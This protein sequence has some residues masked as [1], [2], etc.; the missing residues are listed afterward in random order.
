MRPLYSFMNLIQHRFASH[1]CETL[2]MRS[3]PVVTQ[4]MLEPVDLEA[5]IPES[6]ELIVS[7]ENLFLFAINELEGNLG[8][9]MTDRFAS[10]ALRV[11]LIVLSGQPFE[12][13]SPRSVLKSKRKEH[14]EVPRNEGAKDKSTEKRATPEAFM[15]ALEKMIKNSLLGLDTGYLRSLATHQTGNPML[16]LMLRLELTSFGKQHAN[17][18]SSI[19]RKLL[20]DDP[21]AEGTES[22]AF[23]NGL[24]Y[25]PIGSRLLEAIVVYAPGKLF[26]AL[27]REFFRERMG[28]LARNEIASYVVEKIMER[29]SSDDL[30]KTYDAILPQIPNLAERGRTSVLRI[31]IE[32]SVARGLDTAPLADALQQAY[33]DDNSVSF[34]LPKLLNLPNP[35]EPNIDVMPMRT[36]VDM[37]ASLSEVPTEL[38]PP[39][40]KPSQATSA[41]QTNSRTL[42]AS[43]LAQTM[44]RQPGPLSNLLF[45][46]LPTISSNVILAFAF[47]P[48]LS[49]ILQAALTVSHAPIE[50]RRKI[51]KST[52]SHNFALAIDPSGSHLVDAIWLGTSGLGFARERI[53]EELAENESALRESPCGRKVWKNWWMDL[54]KRR[55]GE[56]VKKVRGEAGNDGFLSFPGGIEESKRSNLERSV[57]G[58]E[59]AALHRNGTDNLGKKQQP[60][61]PPNPW[62]ANG[63]G[64]KGAA[65]ANGRQEG[66]VAFA[67]GKTKL[68]MA[69]EKF[70]MNQ[71]AQQQGTR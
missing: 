55:R 8:F 23:I 20:P 56:W 70:A 1:C 16:Q 2:F 35:I 26:K 63:K 31:L 13:T 33:T 17:D 14:I 57:N 43:L 15:S 46:S 47:T 49:P 12:E 48:T 66:A 36:S 42:H 6:G 25:D 38:P 5:G 69:R 52:Y 4:E 19:I 10:H 67:K 27:Y 53:A 65:S 59:A 30:Q 41:L 21:I 29:L 44:I 24:L 40:I 68:D 11:L 71:K 9:L 50:F 51:I 3:A 18:E 39:N 32:R 60:V 54:Y 62:P 45:N 64:G 37:S 28:S 34:S 58:A 61:G 7:M 22:A